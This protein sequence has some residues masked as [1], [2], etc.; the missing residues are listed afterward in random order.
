MKQ[1]IDDETKILS[2]C[3]GRRKIEM[4]LLE[5]AA[6]KFVDMWKINDGEWEKI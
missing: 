1:F 3:G 6:M 5:A 2:Y 4:K